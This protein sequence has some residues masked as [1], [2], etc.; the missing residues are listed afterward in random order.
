MGIAFEVDGDGS[1]LVASLRGVLGLTDVAKVHVRLLKALAE[2]PDV[3]LLDLADLTVGEPLALSVFTAA[4][5]QA[6]RWPGTPVLLC[7]PPPD[8]RRLL[9]GPAYRQLPVFDSL[10]TASRYAEQR[11]GQA[12]P[13]LTDELLPVSGAARH[14]RNLASEACLLWDLPQLVAPASLIASELV[15]NVVDHAHTMMTLQL[16]LRRRFFHIAVRDG[17]PA[18]PPRPALV[19]AGAKRGRGLLLVDVTASAWGWLPS[20]DGKVVWAS[21]RR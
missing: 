10:A 14:A 19:P 8:T 7:A 12:V 2:Q 16:T 20:A 17:S 15:S 1:T 6:S 11:R 4:S 18:E 9:A 3:L 21:L 13:A 5:S